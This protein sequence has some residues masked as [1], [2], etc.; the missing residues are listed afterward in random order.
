MERAT[1]AITLSAAERQDL[2]SLSRRRK[3]RQGLARRA[4]IVLSAPERL[5]NRARDACVGADAI[6]VGKWRRRFAERGLDGL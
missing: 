1:V 4:R 6:M 2:E 3:T 5:E